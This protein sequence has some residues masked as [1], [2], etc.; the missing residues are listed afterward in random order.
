MGLAD[1]IKRLNYD[2]DRQSPID[3]KFLDIVHSDDKEKFISK[4]CLNVDGFRLEAQ[5]LL[6][7]V[8]LYRSSIKC[9]EAL[10][11]GQTPLN[12]DLNL[13]CKSNGMHPLH[14]VAFD[15]CMPS[16]VELLLCYGAR[17]NSRLKTSAD[18]LKEYADMLP[19]QIALK[20]MT[21]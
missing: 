20:R 7:E 10:I 6:N 13:P 5:T 17:T 4:I 1:Y 14:S 12:V 2:L 16:F 8:L 18:V 15:P 19:L 21:E 3:M 9:A 11:T